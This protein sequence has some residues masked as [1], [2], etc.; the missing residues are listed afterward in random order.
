MRRRSDAENLAPRRVILMIYG[1]VFGLLW[2]PAHPL[3]AA[4]CALVHHPAPSEADTAFLAGNFA[5]AAELYQAALTKNPGQEDVAIGLV[6][7]LLRQQKIQGAADAV[8]ASIGD[9][10]A[11]A[12][13]L[14]LRAEVE[15]RQGQP[16]TAAETANA[17]AKLDP[18]NPRTLLM[19]ARVAG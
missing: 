2:L 10:P 15:L 4:N 8:H 7:A 5:K 12:A 16:W 18:C 19:I 11:P 1:F 3:F 14:T 13:L 6:H 17:S 9:K